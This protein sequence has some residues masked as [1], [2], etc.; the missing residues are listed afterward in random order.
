MDF[1]PRRGETGQVL[2]MVRERDNGTL[3]TQGS[4]PNPPFYAPIFGHTSA[5][6][7]CWSDH[8]LGGWEQ[9]GQSSTWVQ[10]MACFQL[11]KTVENSACQNSLRKKKI[12]KELEVWK[13]LQ[14]QLWEV[15]RKD[16]LAWYPSPAALFSGKGFNLWAQ[17]ETT[18]RTAHKQPSPVRTV[19]SPWVGWRWRQREGHS[20]LESPLGTPLSS[21]NRSQLIL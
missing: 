17:H 21:P 15:C 14:W 9:Q 18:S 10:S 20:S 2:D 12:P 8:F 11:Y 7:L 3:P 4:S 13:T 5:W 6:P 19:L 16:P 1:L